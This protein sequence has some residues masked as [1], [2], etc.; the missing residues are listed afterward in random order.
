MSSHFMSDDYILDSWA[1]V[2]GSWTVPVNE[3][4]YYNRRFQVCYK[5]EEIIFALKHSDSG[6]YMEKISLD[7][8]FYGLV[9]TNI[10]ITGGG[11]ATS[12]ATFREAG[13]KS[14]CI[15]RPDTPSH[16]FDLHFEIEFIVSS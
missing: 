10:S 11:S 13:R 2:S 9:K 1:T 4:T 6:F 7:S 12:G 8:K 15:G 3:T 14:W 5:G 16:E